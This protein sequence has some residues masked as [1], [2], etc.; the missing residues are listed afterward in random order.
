[1]AKL[2]P[3][4]LGSGTYYVPDLGTVVNGKVFDGHDE[5]AIAAFHEQ[6][7]KGV[8]QSVEVLAE[9]DAAIQETVNAPAPDVDRG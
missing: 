1:M 9:R 2:D 3:K 5:K 7:Q 8:E 4:S 6:D